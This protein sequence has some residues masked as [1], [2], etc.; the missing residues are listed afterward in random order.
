MTPF[1][2]SL[3]VCNHPPQMQIQCNLL[4]STEDTFETLCNNQVTMWNTF[5]P[6]VLV[7]TWFHPEQQQ[8]EVL[9][10]LFT[11]SDPHVIVHFKID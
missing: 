5:D 10:F 8:K 4:D 1:T 3:Q 11:D 7:S 9:F 6:E 2:L